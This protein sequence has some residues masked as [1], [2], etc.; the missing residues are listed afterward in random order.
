MFIAL[1]GTPSSGKD[2]IA[3]YLISGHGFRRIEL[4]KTMQDGA[5]S[6]EEEDSMTESVNVSY[7]IR[8]GYFE[9]NFAPQLLDLSKLQIDQTTTPPD[10]A[11]PLS[12]SSVDSLLNSVTKTWRTHYVTTDLQRAEDIQRFVKRPFFLLVAVDGPLMTRFEREKAK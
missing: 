7:E 3:Q 9:T 8:L 2:T 6:P 4:A 5:N 11:E 10:S 1:I 12:F